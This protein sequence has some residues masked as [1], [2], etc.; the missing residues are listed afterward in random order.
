MDVVDPVEVSECY[1]G[2][3]EGEVR[4]LDCFVDYP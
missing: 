3:A 4:E 2:A 1:I